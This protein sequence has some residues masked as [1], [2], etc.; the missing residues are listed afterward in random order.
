MHR[1]ALL[2]LLLVSCCRAEL[3]AAVVLAP[4]LPTAFSTFRTGVPCAGVAAVCRPAAANPCTTSL[5]AAAGAV[6]KLLTATAACLVCTS[7]QHLARQNTSAAVTGASSCAA[8]ASWLLCCCCCCC[9]GVLATRLG[10]FCFLLLQKG[11]LY[12]RC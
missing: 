3:P 12:L 9:C 2:L 5:T 4:P 8:R 11:S 6:G 7:W 10:T 1:H